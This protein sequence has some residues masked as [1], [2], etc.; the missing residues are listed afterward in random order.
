VV[1]AGSGAL[2]VR[3]SINAQWIIVIAAVGVL[4]LGIY[5]YQ[6]VQD[7]IS[8]ASEASSAIAASVGAGLYMVLV[9][10]GFVIVGAL[11]M[12]PAGRRASARRSG[13]KHRTGHHPS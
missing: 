7:R 3:G 8:A 1:L 11:A 13:G 10:A 6:Q 12:L 5:D 9:G 4:A 2:L